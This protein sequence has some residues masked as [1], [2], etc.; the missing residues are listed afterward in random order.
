MFDRPEVPNFPHRLRPRRHRDRLPIVVV[1]DMGRFD[2][3]ATTYRADDEDE[4][5]RLIEALVLKL[6]PDIG[7]VEYIAEANV[8]SSGAGF[9]SVTTKG[10]H[11]DDFGR[12]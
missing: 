11:N 8:I 5:L 10:P 6:G 1:A 12:G 3:G 7:W 9:N 4:L 2:D